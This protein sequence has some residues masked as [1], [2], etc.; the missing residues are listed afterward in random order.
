[1]T[2]TTD[3]EDYMQ[4]FLWICRHKL[5][6]GPAADADLKKFAEAR[7]VAGDWPGKISSF[8]FGQ[9]KP[10]DLATAAGAN[11]G[12]V[13]EAWYYIAIREE[14]TGH[15]EAA[16]TAYQRCQATNRTAFI[17]YTLATT[18]LK[19]AEGGGPAA[20]AAMPAPAADR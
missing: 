11:S 4:F 18:A 19:E 17:E 10:E 16:R 1:M 20:R 7:G 6:E 8:L 12:Q 14:L 5:G 9:M 3:N 15:A 2:M 13:C